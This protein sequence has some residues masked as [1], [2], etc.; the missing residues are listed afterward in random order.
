MILDIFPNH[1]GGDRI[2]HGSGKVPVFPEFS[3]PK[4]FLDPRKFLKHSTRRNAFQHADHFGYRV[5]RR[6]AQK[7]MYVIF[8]DF[9]RIDFPIEVLSDLLEK[10]SH[11]VAQ[12]PTQNPFTVFGGPNQMIFGIVNGMA[13]SL[14]YHANTVTPWLAF[15]EKTFP[16]RPKDGVSK[17]LKTFMN[18][19]R[20]AHRATSS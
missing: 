12:I 6:K 20:G 17:V 8:G 2:A 5:A 4:L 14:Q 19:G 11:T 13:S 7:Y 10:F 9:H 3:T 15:G 16:P 18:T 1:L